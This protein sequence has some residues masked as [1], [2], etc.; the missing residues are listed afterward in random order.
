M[1]T[2]LYDQRQHPDLQRNKR[3][4]STPFPLSASLTPRKPIHCPSSRT[5]MNPQTSRDVVSNFRSFQFPKSATA[6]FV[7]KF[8]NNLFSALGSLGTVQYENTSGSDQELTRASSIFIL[9]TP[10]VAQHDQET[11][12]GAK[13]RV[14]DVEP[15]GRPGFLATV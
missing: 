10:A 7:R 2:V 5:L 6:P 4:Q 15:C 13:M 14:G 1:D 12:H 11:D 3:C 9:L 8:E